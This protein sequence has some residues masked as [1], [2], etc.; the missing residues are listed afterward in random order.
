M[1]AIGIGIALLA[2]LF[3]PNRPEPN[4][5]I[6]KLILAI[7][8]TILIWE[9]NL[10]IDHWFNKNYSWL[11]DTRKRL[12]IQ[13]IVSPIFTVLML[14]VILSSAHLFLGQPDG[15]PD[16]HP[17]GH[18]DPL[19]IPGL[20]IAFFIITIDISNQFL[21]SWK[22]SILE[23]EKYKTE[24]AKAQLQ[25]L[26]SQL[27][28][29]FLFNNLSVLTSLV[30][31]SQD[32]A[33]EFINELS[34][35]YRYV[36]ENKNIELTLLDDE[37]AFL[38]H[39]IYLLKIRFN[40][41]LI[42]NFNIDQNMRNQYLPPMCLQMLVENTIQHNE[43]SQQNPLTVNIYTSNNHLVVENIIQP[44]TDKVESS[45]MGITNMQSRYS[46]FTEDKVIISNDNHIF[47]VVLPLI[48]RV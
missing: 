30:Y 4:N 37:L 43:S 12:I 14:F 48:A 6:F 19:F 10:R 41:N 21:K 7:I 35:V 13:V 17:D 42:F 1:V 25:N 38:D 32:K 28:P 26:V 40:D 23:V 36:L 33:V 16:G 46:F 15:P 39:Y 18:F 45:K 3:K 27:N 8:S 44:R 22:E 47:K 29:H 11:I 34:K 20:S 9:G 5:I 31:K 24:N 2:E